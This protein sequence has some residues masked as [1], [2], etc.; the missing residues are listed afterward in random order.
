MLLFI[1]Q[2]LLTAAINKIRRDIFIMSPVNI[3]FDK[4]ILQTTVGY[5]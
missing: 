4:I 5:L 2:I 3:Y 1:S